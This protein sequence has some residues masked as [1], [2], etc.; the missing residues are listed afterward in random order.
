MLNG[1]KDADRSNYYS[2]KRT[3][4]SSVAFCTPHHNLQPNLGVQIF[5]PG[6][7]AQTHKHPFSFLHIFSTVIPFTRLYPKP[8]V[9]NLLERLILLFR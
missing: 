3:T 7:Q 9:Q 5:S 2:M 8:A 6:P 4:N 1:L